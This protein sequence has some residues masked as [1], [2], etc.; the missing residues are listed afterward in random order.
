MIQERT[1]TVSR[2]LVLAIVVLLLLV[3][4]LTRAGQKL[5]PG[6]RLLQLSGF[7]NSGNLPPDPVSVPTS[8]PAAVIAVLFMLPCLVRLMRSTDDPLPNSPPAGTVP[9]LRAP[10]HRIAA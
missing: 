2:T 10:P 1:A 6:G 8:V 9:S 7:S 3:P 4:G 5:D